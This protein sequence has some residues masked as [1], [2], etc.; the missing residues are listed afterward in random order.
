MDVAGGGK[1][2]ALDAGG[3]ALAT[4]VRK[5][6]ADRVPEGV[7]DHGARRGAR[8]VDVEAAASGRVDDENVRRR[9]G[10]A[11]DGVG[12]VDR[13]Y[14]LAVCLA[15]DDGVSFGWA[16]RAECP[17]QER[18]AVRLR[19]GNPMAHHGVVRGR[20]SHEA[21]RILDYSEE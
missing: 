16:V 17:V 10:Y 4:D 15:F 1:G 19:E 3:E 14:G 11:A 5:G 9:V 20:Q 18:T 12:G 8:E 7:E 6:A 2:D 21:H 13:E